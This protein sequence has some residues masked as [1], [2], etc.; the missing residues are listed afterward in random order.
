MSP[1]MRAVV[2]YVEDRRNCLLIEPV[3]AAQ[4]QV[5]ASL[6]PRSR[7]PSRPS[8]SWRTTSSPP[9]PCPTPMPAASS[10]YES[11]EGGAGVLRQ[12]LATPDALAKVA[13]PGPAAV[14][15]RSRHRRGLRRA[16]GAREDCEAACYD[17]LMSYANQLD[18]KLLDRM[19]SATCSWTWRRA[20]CTPARCPS[21]LEGHLGYLKALCDSEL[22]RSWLDFLA[23]HDLRCRPAQTLIE[24]CGP[25]PTSSTPMSQPRCTSTDRCN[26]VSPTLPRRTSR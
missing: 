7:T 12:L 9:S 11:A 10:S 17:C 15:L 19:P 5:M 18:H 26:I 23:E 25:G 14:P 6:Q 8:T 4:A 20:W 22:E 21:R 1:R 24:A 2:P 13:A 16:P 3:R